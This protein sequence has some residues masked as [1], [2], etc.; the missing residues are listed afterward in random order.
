M[1]KEIYSGN[2]LVYDDGR[3]YSNISHKFLKPDVDK[4]GY[5]QVS[6]FDENRKKIREKVHRLVAKYF[7]RNDM[8]FP[9]VNHKDGDK[10]N[11]NVENLEWCTAYHNNKHARDTG[12][13]P[14]SQSNSKR[15]EDPE[16]R[17]RT[18]E[19]FRRMHE[20]IDFKGRKNPNFRYNL[21]YR[22]EMHTIKELQEIFGLKPGKA[23]KLAR[24][25]R[26]GVP[27]EWTGIVEAV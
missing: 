4:I 8:N 1:Y 17:K 12:L 16:F 23:F 21:L 24:F 5:M 2:Y 10:S 27:C 3:V 15:W 13:N 18:S 26:E 19:S 25:I 14:V 6:L 11:N 9:Q 22:G 20:K 7:L